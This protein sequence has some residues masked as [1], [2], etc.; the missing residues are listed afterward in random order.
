LFHLSLWTTKQSKAAE[1]IHVIP[2]SRDIFVLL[3]ILSPKW[4]VSTFTR[5]KTWDTQSP[6][7]CSKVKINNIYVSWK[8]EYRPMIQLPPNTPGTCIQFFN[9]IRIMASITTQNQ[10][11]LDTLYVSLSIKY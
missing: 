1:Y 9:I 3:Y 2:S 4:M 7:T 5:R 6:C 8:R 11:P 10:F